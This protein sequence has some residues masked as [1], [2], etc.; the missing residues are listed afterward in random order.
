MPVY[1]LPTQKRVRD[2]GWPMTLLKYPVI[3][4]AYLCLLTFATAAT[5]LVTLVKA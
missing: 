5:F 2:Q 4:V 1:L 3:G